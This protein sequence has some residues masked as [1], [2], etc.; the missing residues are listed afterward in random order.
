MFLSQGVPVHSPKAEETGPGLRFVPP[1]EGTG[2]ALGEPLPPDTEYRARDKQE[3]PRRKCLPQSA[4]QQRPWWVTR[5]E[6]PRVCQHL[7]HPGG[8]KH[9]AP[10]RYFLLALPGTGFAEKDAMGAVLRERR[11]NLTPVAPAR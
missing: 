9:P 11:R 6:C 4:K 1:G 7:R 2:P 8:S 5:R 3:G 10:T